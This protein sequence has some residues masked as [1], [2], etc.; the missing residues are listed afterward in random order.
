MKIRNLFSSSNRT[1]QS[2]LCLDQYNWFGFNFDLFANI[3]KNTGDTYHSFEIRN[4]FNESN[5]RNQESFYKDVNIDA[6]I[7]YT[8]CNELELV[9][10]Q[11]NLQDDEHNQVIN[12]WRSF[13]RICVDYTLG[14]ISQKGITR[15]LIPQGYVLEAAICRLI[16]HKLGLR[17][18]AIENTMVKDRLLWDNVSG[19]TVNSNLAKN[20]FWKYKDV[21]DPKVPVLFVQDYIQNIKSLKSD[22]HA[23]P[24]NSPEIPLD[25][26]VIV[27]LGQVYVDSSVL[28]GLY[29]G[30]KDQ[31]DII[32]FLAEYAVRNDCALIVKLHPKEVIGNS[33]VNQPLARLTWRKLSQSAVF[34]DYY[35]KHNDVIV[36][37]DNEFDTYDLINNATVCV[38]VNSMAGLE[39]CLLNKPTITCGYSSYGCLGFTSEATN[40][41]LLNYY[42]DLHSSCTGTLA[43]NDICKLFFYTYLNLYCIE[44]SEAALTTKIIETI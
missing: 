8:V 26:K 41:D 15:I 28:F 6:A 11:I 27:F 9:P 10:S 23:T 34:M 21:V 12:K 17:L 43:T 2:I 44:K 40:K 30:Y 7:C 36:D 20:Y 3:V 13:A 37:Y 33:M 39:S 14:T 1:S 25:K 4:A 31:V 38:T 5:T 35:N 16:A 29:D 22:E 19:I 24:R 18:L 32:E 42:L